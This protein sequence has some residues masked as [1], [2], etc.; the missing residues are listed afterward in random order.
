MQCLSPIS[1]VDPKG[2]HV[3]QRITVPCGKCYACLS[4]RRDSWSFRIGQELKVSSAA[5]FITL[6]YDDDHL[7]RSDGDIPIVLRSDVQLFMKRLRKSISPYKIRYFL[8]AEYGTLT[9][10]PHYHLILFNFPVD[11]DLN[12]YLVSSW[13]KGHCHVG[14]VTGQSIHYVT[15]YCLEVTDLPSELQLYRPFMLCSTKPAI[16]SN[17]LTDNMKLWQK[18]GLKSY[19]VKDGFKQPMPRYYKEKVFDKF[20]KFQISLDLKTKANESQRK[21]DKKD[22][23]YDYKAI[24]QNRATMQSQRKDAFNALMKKRINKSS[25]I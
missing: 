19:V 10:R 18:E 9:Y 13:Q 23:I 6:T 22:R 24:E 20:E 15:K 1:I 2:T 5:H 21:I 12:Q 14:S 7:P 25:K 16:G 17:Y 3:S 11:C 8:V 4:R